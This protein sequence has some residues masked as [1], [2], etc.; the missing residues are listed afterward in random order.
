MLSCNIICHSQ[1]ETALEE[2]VQLWAQ[3]IFKTTSLTIEKD[4]FF[5]VLLC[6]DM[7]IKTLN[8]T[9]RGKNKPTNILSFPNDEEDDDE[10]GIYLG[11]LIIST[12][13]MARESAEMNIPIADHWRHI[14]IHGI[15]HLLGHDHEDEAEAEVMENLEI[16]WLNAMGIKNPYAQA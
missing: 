5:S 15:L 7:H 3:D 11:D 1:A 13:T 12:T 10:E 8:S 14:I 4:T 9:Y 16:Q 2:D 6:D